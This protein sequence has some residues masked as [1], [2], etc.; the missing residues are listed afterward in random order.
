MS[1]P[2]TKRSSGSRPAV[3]LAGLIACALITA[4]PPAFAG[5]LGWTVY[6]GR[7]AVAK[8]GEA[9]EVGAEIRRPLGALGFDA[10]AGLA[11]TADEAVWGYAGVAFGWDVT[12]RW[13]LRPG[14]AVSLFDKGDGRDLGG[15]LE[16][17]SSL[18]IARRFGRDLRVGL[19]YYH[20]SNARLYDVNPGSNSMVLVVG[21]Q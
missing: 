13:Q 11:G 4:V 6:A 2:G 3:V 17:R 16:F 1:G 20:L 9:T 10:A 8:D 14:F 15:P 12:E 5:E 19:L 7:W 21:F 18:E